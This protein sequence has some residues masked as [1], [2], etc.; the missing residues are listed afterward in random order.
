MK[1]FFYRALCGFLL[2]IAVLAPGISGSVIAVV[3]GIYEKLLDII[4]NP[5]KDF[6]R[7]IGWLVPLGI[8]AA[9][10]FGLFVLFFNSLFERYPLAAG[11][12]FFGL[13]AGNLP[14][15]IKD[16][17]QSPL[18]PVYLIPMAAGFALALGLGILRLGAGESAAPDALWYFAVC[19]LVAGVCSMVPGV[20]IS[21][22][23]ILLGVYDRLLSAARGCLDELLGLLG[24]NGGAQGFSSILLAAVTALS[25][26]VGMVAFSRLTRLLIS[27]CRAPVYWTILAFVCGS[28]GAL[29]ISLPYAR[30]GQEWAQSVCSLVLGVG[31]ALGFVALGRRIGS[32]SA[33]EQ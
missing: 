9:A 26:A 12:L 14:A 30:F 5:L 8:G 22:I 4:A 20:S 33:G 31:L 19:G 18:K 11:L 15:V 17:R 21:L 16:A 2:G 23:L 29:L 3:M 25:F 27:R 24:V 1:Q 28:L 32:S 6:K 10:S 7:N 13:V